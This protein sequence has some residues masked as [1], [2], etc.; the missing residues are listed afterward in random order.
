[1]SKSK[2]ICIVTGSR[3]EYGLLNKLLLKLKKDKSFHLQ[4]V[5]T[6][7]HLSKKYGSTVNEIKKDYINIDRK[8]N[9]KLNN[10]NSQGVGKSMSIALTGFVKNYEQLKP[11]IILL[12]GDRYEILTAAI[13]A[14]L[15]RIPIGHI[16][17][18]ES[19]EGAIDDAFRHS[20]TKMSHIHFAAT[21]EYKKRIIQM[22]ENPKNVH[23]VGG[24][25][26]DNIVNKKLLNK[27]ELEKKLKLKFLK[28]SILVTYHPETLNKKSSQNDFKNLISALTKLKDTTIIFTMPN[29]DME[30]NI[31]TKLIKDF[32][33]LKKNSFLFKSLGQ[34]K[35]YSCCNQVNC[36]VGNSSSGLLEMPSFK[37]FSINIGSRQKGRMKATS[38]IDCKPNS[39]DVL[40]CL[41]F[42]FN[43]SNQKKLK[44]IINP[45]GN[46]GA[47]KKIISILKK[48]KFMKII[49][50]TFFDLKI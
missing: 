3:A 20:I 29:S 50:K 40:K 31:I 36:M 21:E 8:I 13:A 10:D 2:K 32:I 44:N 33:R 37:K 34:K 45:Y 49:H 43:E 6:G 5:V 27:S 28:K 15:C 9:L 38:V 48:V 22:G 35:Y 39:N 18:G 19:T 4:L 26:V 16:H 7:S 23:C 17:G 30:S 42:V 14:T 11:D 41:N 47:T 24:L 25:G 1:M 46:G 12:L